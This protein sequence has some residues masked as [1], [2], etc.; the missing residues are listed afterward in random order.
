VPGA[1]G[2]EGGEGPLFPQENK[3]G[4]EQG[5]TAGFSAIFPV[6]EKV[7]NDHAKGRAK[8]KE[9]GHEHSCLSP[10]GA[11]IQRAKLLALHGKVLYMYVLHTYL[12]IYVYIYIYVYSYIHICIRTNIYTL[13]FSALS[14]L[15]C[16]VRRNT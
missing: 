14:C 8:N 10:G 6:A 13:T 2:G 16:K 7:K 11:D 15:R 3:D 9:N 5:R 1:G 12:Y 4:T